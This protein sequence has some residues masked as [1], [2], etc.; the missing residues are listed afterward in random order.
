MTQ[1]S[2]SESVISAVGEICG[3]TP[4]PSSPRLNGESS[5][6]PK[7]RSSKELI[8]HLL[9]LSAAPP[10]DTHSAGM[11]GV[12]GTKKPV[13]RQP[14][15]RFEN[16]DP[17]RRRPGPF[18]RATCRSTGPRRLPRCWSVLI[19]VHRCFHFL[20][21]RPLTSSAGVRSAG[22]RGDRALEERTECGISN[23]GCGA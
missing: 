7:R 11:M 17:L 21:T 22:A 19:R 12:Y 13:P 9:P 6:L 16:A 18:A 1:M 3:L 15:A 5:A 4:L 23:A 14:K 10:P 20:S 2:D 8:G